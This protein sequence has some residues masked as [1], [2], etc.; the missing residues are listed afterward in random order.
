M[1]I[2][3]IFYDKKAAYYTLGCKLNYA[4]TST[5]ME[6]FLRAGVITIQE[7]ENPD[8]VII[9]TCSV[10]EGADKK[11]RNLIHRIRKKY[12]SAFLVVTGCYAQLHS[13]NIMKIEGVDLVVGVSEKKNLCEYVLNGE[14]GVIV[15]SVTGRQEFTPACSYSGR[16]RSFLKIQDGCDYACSYCAIPLARGRSRSSQ[17]SDV[18]R[19]AKELGEKGIKEIVLTGVNIGDFGKSTGENFLDL[20]RNLDNIKNINRFR[21]SSIEPNL[22]SDKVIEFIAFSNRFVPHFHIPLQ[23]GSDAV[24]QLMHRRYN[25]ELFLSKIK[26]IKTFMTDAFIGLDIIVGMRGETEEYFRESQLFLE[27][28]PFSQLHVFT[29]SERLGTMALD[30]G[31][32]V[33]PKKKQERRK[34]LLALSAKRYKDFY[35]SQIGTNHS[36]LFENNRKGNKMFGFTENYIK[37]EIEYDEKFVNQLCDVTLG[38]WNECTRALVLRF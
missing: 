19:N 11:S 18:V 32:I 31:Q 34:E 6:C 1:M 29:Y 30:V 37:V 3:N 10:T 14:K 7:G 36:V 26:K 24:L 35:C 5:I 28:L 16:T 27:N 22:L 8:I 25:R 23:S 33:T 4:E 38:E 21:I 20:L 13:R 9:S 15:S 12:S 2:D 17:I